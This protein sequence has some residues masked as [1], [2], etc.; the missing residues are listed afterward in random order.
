LVPDGFKELFSTA[1]SNHNLFLRQE[2]DR[3]SLYRLNFRDRQISLVRDNIDYIWHTQSSPNSDSYFVVQT[4]DMSYS[5]ELL[6]VTTNEQFYI[7]G[8]LPS[9]PQVREISESEV[10]IIWATSSGDG[11]VRYSLPDRT[12]LSYHAD[13]AS[14]WD[15]SR[16]RL[17]FSPDN[18]Y[19]A[20]SLQEPNGTA[21]QIA[22]L[23]DLPPIKLF[24]SSEWFS[25]AGMLYWSPDSS[26][27]LYGIAN[28]GPAKLVRNDGSE[29]R[30]F[31]YSGNINFSTCD[32]YFDSQVAN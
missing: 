16:T 29:L 18:R 28:G 6:N 3:L 10:A 11:L 26:R 7:I 23:D 31:A 9:R 13:I 2:A 25:W 1:D 32:E 15:L 12:L 8:N 20:I 17:S 24:Q 4:N 22:S 19:V 14:R 27:L 30:V 21:L 5:V